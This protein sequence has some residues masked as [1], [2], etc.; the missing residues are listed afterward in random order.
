MLYFNGIQL[1][2][3]SKDKIQTLVFA[4]FMENHQKQNE[5]TC[6]GTELFFIGHIK[7]VELK[8]KLHTYL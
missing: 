2:H 4:F 3:C 7:Y 8:N 6:L 1:Y 5:Y